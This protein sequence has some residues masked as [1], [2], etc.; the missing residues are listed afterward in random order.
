MPKLCAIYEIR[1]VPSDRV[2]IGQSVNTRYRL[3]YHRWRLSQGAHSNKKLQRI[4]NKHA[5]GEFEFRVLEVV[6][7][8]QE[9][10]AREIAH[11]AKIPTH[12]QINLAP[13]GR[14]RK[15][16]VPPLETRALWSKQRRGV[17]HTP[18]RRR[19]HEAGYN[20]YGFFLWRS[21]TT[22]QKQGI[23]GTCLDTGRQ[24]FLPW[25]SRAKILGFPAARNAADRK[26]K[27]KFKDG[28]YKGFFW[29]WNRVCLE[30]PHPRIQIS[31]PIPGEFYPG[32]KSD[33]QD[34]VWN[35]TMVLTEGVPDPTGG[36]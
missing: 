33:I 2:Y 20:R 29:E 9:L 13:A 12:L 26:G 7:D 28:I 24:V 6:S 14:S 23:V 35:G 16:W 22:G 10:D 3:Y 18:Q 11:L 1:H 21:K 5:E 30:L 34:G 17:K 31:G 8:P 4:W 25:H 36:M 27:G 15:G 19:S 32:P